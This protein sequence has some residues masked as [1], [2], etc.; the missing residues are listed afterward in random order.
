VSQANE[1]RPGDGT[2]AEKDQQATRSDSSVAHLPQAADAA[3]IA[4]A[5]AI[6]VLVADR[7]GRY[8]RRVFLTLASAQRACEQAAARG[9]DAQIVLCRLSPVEGG[10][11]P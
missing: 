11:L 3:M 4:R 10:E 6:V 5:E 8:R 7:R 2:E 9:V 1:I